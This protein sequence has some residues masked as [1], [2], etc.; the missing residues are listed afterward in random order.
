MLGGVTSGR[1]EWA[2]R[3][4][5]DA[6]RIR[7]RR[8][9]FT[10]GCEGNEEVWPEK[11]GS[12]RC[13]PRFP[14]LARLLP[15]A[16]DPRRQHRKPRVAIV[17]PGI[18]L[19]RS[20]QRLSR[21][22]RA[23]EMK[24]CLDA[25]GSERSQRRDKQQCVAQCSGPGQDG[26]SAICSKL[27]HL[28]VWPTST[29]SRA[30]RCGWCAPPATR[31]IEECHRVDRSRGISLGPLCRSGLTNQRASWSSTP[32]SAS[33]HNPGARFRNT[34]WAI[35]THSGHVLARRYELWGL[36]TGWGEDR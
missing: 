23:D 18:N 22:G 3:E 27:I 10:A 32:Q 13:Q 36:A 30:M 21:T 14:R 2:R 29:G 12:Q 9:Q 8:D 11:R 1:W 34:P 35:E 6:E 15:P 28:G 7:R 33:R 19:S 17:G 25:P 5:V 20:Q 31:G 4:V 26:D 24:L 16:L